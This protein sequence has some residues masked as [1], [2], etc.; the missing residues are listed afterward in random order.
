MPGGLALPLCLTAGLQFEQMLSDRLPSLQPC[1]TY[2]PAI[3]HSAG[4]GIAVNPPLR[5]DLRPPIDPRVRTVEP[6]Q[7]VAPGNTNT[8]RDNDGCSS[9]AHAHAIPG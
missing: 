8:I 9:F 4:R 2:L 6:R 7:T 1:E 3:P 5:F